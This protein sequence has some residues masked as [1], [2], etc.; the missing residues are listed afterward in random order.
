VFQC[1]LF[2]PPQPPRTRWGLGA[3]PYLAPVHGGV[4][5]C[6]LFSPRTRGGVGAVPYL[7][8]V[9][10]GLGGLFPI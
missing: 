10:G 2:S 5:G 9:H 6:S 8:P 4:G 3:V 7:A 1:S